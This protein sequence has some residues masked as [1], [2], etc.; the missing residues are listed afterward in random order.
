MAPNHAQLHSNLGMLLIRTG[1]RQEGAEEIL[2]A[3]QLDPNSPQI[4]K[5]VESLLGP[6]AIQ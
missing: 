1:K 3:F 2:K 5:V 4:R 6:K